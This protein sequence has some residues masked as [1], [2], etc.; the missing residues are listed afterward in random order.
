MKHDIGNPRREI[1]AVGQSSRCGIV[2][3]YAF[4]GVQPSPQMQ[5]YAARLAHVRQGMW[6]KQQSRLAVLTFC[7]YLAMLSVDA[8]RKVAGLPWSVIGI[9]YLITAVIYIVA[10]PGIA[11]R[12][13]A[14]PRARARG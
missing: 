2:G 5:G 13:H 4:A 6:Q 8:V 11:D 7:L 10:I 14:F 12:G 3:A 9:I 1:P